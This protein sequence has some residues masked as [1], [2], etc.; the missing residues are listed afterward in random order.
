MTAGSFG[1][2]A[3]KISV[4]RGKPPVIRSDGEFVRD[5]FHVADGAGAYLKLAECLAERPELAGEAF[6]FSLEAPLTALELVQQIL[7]QMNSTL[8]PEIRG[9]ATNEIRNQHLSAAKARE[10]LGLRFYRES[11]LDEI[12]RTL[13]ISLSAAKMRLY[14]ALEQFEA[15]YVDGRRT[16]YREVEPWAKPA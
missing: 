10:V 5:Y 2:R 7:R 6:N 14:R 4:T 1:L 11:S 12:A 16:S 9:E 3:S 15:S 13:G 8:R